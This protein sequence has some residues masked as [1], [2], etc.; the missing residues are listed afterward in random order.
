MFNFSV[1]VMYLNYTNYCNDRAFPQYQSFVQLCIVMLMLYI[2]SVF[3]LRFVLEFRIKLPATICYYLLVCSYIVKSIMR[4]SARFWS[5][6]KNIFL[7]IVCSDN[8]EVR[9]WWQFLIRKIFVYI[10]LINSSFFWIFVVKVYKNRYV[11][12]INNIYNNY[13]SHYFN[14]IFC[15]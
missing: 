6:T 11:R 1:H 5:S 10:F 7:E 3:Q 12:I 8:N 15:F 2:Y 14:R 4:G 9:R 13:N